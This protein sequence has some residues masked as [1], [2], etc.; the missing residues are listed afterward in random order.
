MS[1][2]QEIISTWSMPV[3]SL[4]CVEAARLLCETRNGAFV[5]SLHF[6]AIVSHLAGFTR[7]ER[8]ARQAI[9]ASTPLLE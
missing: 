4:P 7:C 3:A 8:E 1:G 5:A 6:D 9:Q 2:I